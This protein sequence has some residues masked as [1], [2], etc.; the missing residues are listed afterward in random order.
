VRG[1]LA[2]PATE[3]PEPVIKGVGRGP[4]AAG[5]VGVGLT[6]CK[7]GGEGDADHL[8]AIT[9][10]G[11]AGIGQEHMCGPTASQAG[12]PAGPERGAVQ[13]L[14]PAGEAPTG[15]D[16]ALAT[17]A[18][19]QPGRKVGLYGLRVVSYDEHGCLRHPWRALSS[20]W[21]RWNEGVLSRSWTSPRCRHQE[22][23]RKT[24][25]P[26]SVTL[27]A[28]LV[29][30]QR[31][32]QHLPGGGALQ[33]SESALGATVSACSFLDSLS[34]WCY[35]RAMTDCAPAA[36]GRGGMNLFASRTLRRLFLGC[37]G[38]VAALLLAA[39]SAPQL[40]TGVLDTSFHATDGTARPPNK[41]LVPFAELYNNNYAWEKIAT[42][43]QVLKPYAIP[44]CDEATTAF[45]QFSAYPVASE[46]LIDCPSAADIKTL[47]QHTHWAVL[48]DKQNNWRNL[49]GFGRWSNTQATFTKTYAAD[50]TDAC[51][52]F[53]LFFTNGPIFGVASWCEQT[54]AGLVGPV[55][56]QL[57]AQSWFT[58]VATH[59][60]DFVKQTTT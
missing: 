19:Q 9:P 54:Q 28:F 22:L 39:C 43:P 16:P 27:T 17:G 23:A 32:A 33:T 25:S 38:T 60:N 59:V 46:I 4:E 44:G 36:M 37:V 14:A 55:Q 31:G 58:Q 29:T 50:S 24:A 11:E 53:L 15:K 13:Q 57:D 1:D 6:A 41:A 18:A 30:I 2:G 40:P 20:S 52:D 51:T 49:S 7:D 12:G 21:E 42:P 8:G 3:A 47:W 26:C 48:L 35:P 56:V 5:C 10:T 45:D 34:C